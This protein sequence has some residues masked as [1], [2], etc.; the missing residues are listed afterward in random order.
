MTAPALGSRALFPDLEVPYYLNY[1]AV[2]PLSQP[3]REAAVGALEAQARGGAAA[4]GAWLEGLAAARG[5][6]ASIVGGRADEVAVVG[7]TSAG[8]TAVAMGFPWAAGDR[9]LLF[10]GEFPAN[11]TPWQRAAALYGLEL[12]FAPVDALRTDP[13]AFWAAVDR[14][15]AA[16]VRL[17]A[18]SAVQFQTGLRVPLGEL[19]RRARAAGAR[20]F[21]DGIQACGIAPIDVGVGMDFLAAGGH[22]W[23]GGSFGAGFLWA[24]AEGWGLLRPH[25][26]GWLS[27]A[28]GMAFLHGAP[29]LLRYDRPLRT[30]P[31]SV[32]GGA[33]NAAGVAA[34]G[35]SVGLI[36]ALGG[37]AIA[38][39]VEGVLEPLERGLVALG[40]E[41]ARSADPA[42]RA[43]ILATRPPAPWSPAALASALADR[44]V[45]V[46]TPDGWLRFS[47][48]WPTAAADVPAVLARV[49][50]ALRATAA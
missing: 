20:L 32:E 41:S 25:L 43:G 30:G 19:A 28:D 8:V 38:A 5:G 12:V 46:S 47:A 31:S 42:L 14:A 24:S 45:A 2:S 17:V 18:V 23:L 13:D 33:F 35:A 49:A 34:L 37:P 27:H 1:A 16:R 48:H 7:N 21:V 9:V 39:H 44:G 26:A 36:A 22:K 50:D 4:I 3:A 6:F 40:F 29:G 11:V 10:E 15:L